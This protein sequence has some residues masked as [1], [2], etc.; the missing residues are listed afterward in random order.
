MGMPIIK[1]IVILSIMVMSLAETAFGDELDGYVWERM[2][3][4]YKI[5]LMGG[6]VY[7]FRHGTVYGAD[8]GVTTVSRFL[9]DLSA[10]SVYGIRI[11]KDY[12]M[13]GTSIDKNRETVLKAAASYAKKSLHKPIEY[14]V[15]DVDSF[16]KQYP[17][18]RKKYLFDMLTEISLV[19]LN[20]STY[21]DIGEGC[22]KNE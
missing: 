21:K 17:L 13:C 10:S 1:I 20:I 11:Y 5:L 19:W 22:S 4:S 3:E 9:K 16:Y 7:G 6:Y 15:E 2:D 18:C 8:F 12:S 14:Y